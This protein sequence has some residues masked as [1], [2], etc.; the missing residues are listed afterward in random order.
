MD[1]RRQG[2]LT[3]DGGIIIVEAR[4]YTTSKLKPGAVGELAYRIG[5]LGAAGGIIATHIGVQS[6]G[7]KIAK[8]EGIDIFH[9]DK[10]STPTD[11]KLEGL[12]K[13]LAGRSAPFAGHG[14]LTVTAEARRA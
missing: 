6:G 14:D 5:D 13:W 4:R 11:F 8:S 3:D 12:S 9:V 10:D 2:R 1:H 7:V